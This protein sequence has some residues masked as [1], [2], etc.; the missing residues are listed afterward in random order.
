MLVDLIK[1]R[2]A[3]VPKIK[4][5]QLSDGL[6]LLPHREAC[7]HRPQDTMRLHLTYLAPPVDL[8]WRPDY[9]SG[10]IGKVVLPPF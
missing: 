2:D 8:A 6:A 10:E 7:V 1:E 9:S 3:Y 5:C 4:Y